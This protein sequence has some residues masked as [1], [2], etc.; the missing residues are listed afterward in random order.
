MLNTALACIESSAAN[1]RCHFTAHQCQTLLVLLGTWYSV[2]PN[3]F[4]VVT[5]LHFVMKATHILAGGLSTVK[6][7]KPLIRYP[8]LIF[9]ISLKP[10]TRLVIKGLRVLEAALLV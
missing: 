2:V 7:H 8:F 10:P 1:Y 9:L 6:I 4:T 3:I 5:R